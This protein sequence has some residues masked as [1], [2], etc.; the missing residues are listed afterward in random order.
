ML[1]DQLGDGVERLE[2]EKLEKPLD[3]PVVG[4]E[5]ELVELIGTRPG[6]VEP[7]VPQF[8]LAELGAG[9]RGQ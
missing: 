3:V 6:R 9:G 5:P 7:D 1:A 8:A 2:G 4:V